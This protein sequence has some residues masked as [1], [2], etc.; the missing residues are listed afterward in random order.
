MGARKCE[1]R[2][3][4]L[5]RDTHFRVDDPLKHLPPR[6]LPRSGSRVGRARIL[7][8]TA[9]GDFQLKIDKAEGLPHGVEGLE[10]PP[11]SLQGPLG[12][13]YGCLAHLKDGNPHTTYRRLHGFLFNKG[14]KKQ[15]RRPLQ[16]TP[17]TARTPACAPCLSFALAQRPS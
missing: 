1:A 7:L 5:T 8:P 6:V 11:L 4:R 13:L 9:L 2:V 10:Q 17:P 15:E 3:V 14:I 12:R 16:S